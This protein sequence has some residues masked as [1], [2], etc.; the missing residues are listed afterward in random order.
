MRLKSMDEVTDI[1]APMLAYKALKIQ[2]G[3]GKHG[4]GDLFA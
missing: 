2:A 3:A 1:G 4:K